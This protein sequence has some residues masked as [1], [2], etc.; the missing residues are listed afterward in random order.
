MRSRYSAYALGLADYV[1]ATWHASTRPTDTVSDDAV[2][3]IGLKIVQ[4]PQAEGDAAA[5]EFIARYKI[6][7]RAYRMHET[8]RFVREDGRWYYVDGDVTDD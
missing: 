7:G 8:S 4:A 1:A 6:G 2:K 5:V 3:W